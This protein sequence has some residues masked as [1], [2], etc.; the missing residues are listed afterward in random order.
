[1]RLNLTS[2]IIELKTTVCWKQ[3]DVF[4]EYVTVHFLNGEESL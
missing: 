2:P 4:G 1:M 3:S